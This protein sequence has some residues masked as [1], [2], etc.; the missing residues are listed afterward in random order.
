[1]WRVLFEFVVCFFVTAGIIGVSIYLSNFIMSRG[2]NIVDGVT[3]LVMAKGECKKAEYLIRALANATAG[4][5]T[6]EG[7]PNIII[8]DGGMDKKTANVC[9]LLEWDYDFVNV[10]SKDKALEVLKNK[11]FTT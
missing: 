4:I 8:I 7:R 6:V 5:K 1:M 10:F 2:K 3:I 9:T 11:Y